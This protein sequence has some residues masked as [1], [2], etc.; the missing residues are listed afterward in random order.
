MQKPFSFILCLAAILLAFFMLFQPGHSW[1]YTINATAGKGGK[2]SPSGAVTVSGGASQTFFIKPY[3]NNTVA[4]VLIDGGSIGT[5][6][7]ITFF[8]VTSNHT[9]EVSFNLSAEF[10]DISL[11]PMSAIK[12]AA[13]PNIMFVLDDSGSMDWEF[14]TQEWNGLFYD[15]L[16]YVRYVFDDPG[17]NVFPGSEYILSGID[18]MKW[19]SQW[20][21]YNRLY[22]DPS[23][24]YEPWPTL[25]NADPDT[26][27][28]HPMN[29]T[30][31]FALNDTYYLFD[32]GIIIDDLDGEFSK[33]GVWYED[34]G[35]YES[36]DGHFWES[37]PD[38]TPHTATWTPNLTPGDYNV[39][40]WWRSWDTYSTAVPYTINHSGGSPI[41]PVNQRI[42]ERQWNLLG[43]P[44]TFDGVSDKVEISYTP[45]GGGYDL[46][47]A[48][49][50]KFVPTDR[51]PIDIKNAHYYTFE[52]TNENGAYDVGEVYLV[53]MEGQDPT[54]NYK[55][56]EVTIGAAEEVT[57]LVEVAEAS[58]PDWAKSG[59][60]AADERQNFANWY[61]YYRR[62]ELTAAAAVANIIDKMEG[63]NIGFCSINGALVQ[64]VLSV[65]AG[66]ED[67]TADL[68]NGLYNMALVPDT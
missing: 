34:W 32:F 38:S 5:P 13:P 51:S 25:S 28:S 15:G 42:N 56:Y 63:V 14:L 52:D 41:V 10:L 60:N 8:N 65:K 46:V 62:R 39:Y 68:L 66:G 23:V 17:D 33:T 19:K 29:A 49:A 7:T 53:V 40:A 67:Y 1:A 21:G 61:S 9:I 55:Y 11:V 48:D 36:Y 27:S 12:R 37:S 24:T 4:D 59:R 35:H 45:N 58:V 43:G 64:P 31:T 2:I 20:S 18:R 50:V 57:D 22:Y 44:Y 16:Q 6:S 47:C 26:P 3:C 30:P 54:Y